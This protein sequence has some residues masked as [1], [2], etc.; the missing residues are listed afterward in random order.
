MTEFENK[1]PYFQNRI[2]LN[3]EFNTNR[4]ANASVHLPRNKRSGNKRQW[5]Q[6]YVINFT[7]ISFIKIKDQIQISVVPG[8]S[9]QEI[10]KY[11]F[12]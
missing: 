7:K 4:A 8:F 5:A 3:L 10:I 2:H 12:Y 1:I 9:Q 11:R 6:Q